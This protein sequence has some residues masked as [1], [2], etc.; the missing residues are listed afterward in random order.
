VLFSYVV[1]RVI[2]D[3]SPNSIIAQTALNVFYSRVE[4]TAPHLA[5]YMRDMAA[6][7]LYILCKRS[8]HRDDDEIG[9]VF[10]RTCE[11]E[12]NKALVQEGNRLYRSFYEQ[13]VRLHEQAGYIV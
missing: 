12:D 4:E 13:C 9:T 7:S 1:N 5:E 11:D 8:E 10:A 2:A 3:I 6:F